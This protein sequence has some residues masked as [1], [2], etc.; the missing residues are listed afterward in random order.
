MKNSRFFARLFLLATLCI[1][2]PSLHSQSVIPIPQEVE[3]AEGSFTLNANTRLSCN[4]QGDE[5]EQLLDYLKQQP[6]LSACL[7]NG[8]NTPAGQAGIVLQKLDNAGTRTPESYELRVTP[9]RIHI[10]ACT[11]AGLFYGLQS[12]MQLATP[13][14]EGQWKVSACH[15]T[16]QP[17]FAYRGFMMD[18]SRHFRTKEFVKKQMDAM[19]RF[20][21]NRLHLHLTDGAGWRIEIKQYPRLTEFAAWRPQAVWKDWWF[22]GGRQ[23]C[24]EGT[25]GAYG[26]YY[27]QDDIRELLAYAAERHITIIP[28]IEMPAH[29]EE[30][31]AA[32]PEMSCSGEPYKNAEFCIGNEKTFEFLENVL[33]EVMEL[34][35]SEYIHIGGDEANKNPWKAC[36]KCQQRMKDEGLKDVDELQSY[37][38]H[39]M[40][41]F[42]NKHGRKLLGWDEI[43][44]GGL[45]PNATV[46]SWRG[47]E[48]GLKA[49]R[50]GHR[51]VMTPAEFFYLDYYQDAPISQPE[52]IGGYV[53]LEKVYS[54]DPVKADFT[55]EEKALVYGVQANQWAEYISTDEQ[56]EYMMYPRLLAVAE[57]GWSE[58]ERKDFADFRNRALVAVDWMT[59]N[60]YHPFPLKDEVGHRPESRE[61]IE[62]LALGKPVTYNAPFNETY[63]AAGDKSL[64]DGLRGDWTYSDG[65]WQG[66][67]SRNRLDVTIDLGEETQIGSIGAD[68]MQAAGPEVFLPA[69]VIISVSN[70]GQKFKRLKREK[71]KV[72]REPGFAFA[73]H[74]W[75]GK[76]KARYVRVQ[77]RS[78]KELGGWIFTDEIV[79]LPPAAGK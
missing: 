75:K 31:L 62:H 64:T 45:A 1:G 57:V 29:S 18:V 42:L 66:F 9:E 37:A 3:Q 79:V 61:P 12:L 8:H 2:S 26:G 48:G 78:G 74:T 44:E 19:A 60:G 54:Y 67:I 33:A 77:A 30:V 38:I 53:P 7:K 4:L 51:A 43:M 14:G 11:D 50:S 5:L 17:R 56:Y 10:T 20:K 55:P 28:E 68:F 36:P 52:A 76:T 23:Y 24:E 72:S 34:F 71:H 49:I 65:R 40:E 21:L 22:K 59:A 39:R 15:I 47:E 32:Y 73:N 13:A 46:M 16:D 41:V 69:E 63:K 25:P 35:P 70:D 27:T 58:P 6:L